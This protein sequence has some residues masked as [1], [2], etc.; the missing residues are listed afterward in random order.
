MGANGTLYKKKPTINIYADNRMKMM[1]VLNPDFRKLGAPD[2]VMFLY[3]QLA[4]AHTRT[5]K[6]TP[7]AMV[8]N[9]L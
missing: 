7:F 3:N 8:M 6:Y 2:H 5:V 4:T 1:F 9:I